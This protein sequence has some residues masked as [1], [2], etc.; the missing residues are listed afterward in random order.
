MKRLLLVIDSRREKGERKD[1]H[2]RGTVDIYIYIYIDRKKEEQEGRIESKDVKEV[3][4]ITRT[5]F[6][7]RCFSLLFGSDEWIL[8][9]KL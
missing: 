4:K 1:G 6:F 5:I 2:Q 9:S 8:T 3:G 7:R